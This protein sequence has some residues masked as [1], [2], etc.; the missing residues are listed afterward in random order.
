MR[1]ALLIEWWKVRRSPVTLT[2]TALM[3]LVLPAMGLGFYNVALSDAN[4]ILAD[5]AT[6][7][8]VGDGWDG[9]LGLVD[10]IAAVA[11]LL[12]VGVVVAWVF[13]REHVDRTFPSLFAH[14]TSRR[15]MAMAKF[16]VMFG[17]VVVVSLVIAALSFLLGVV[18]GVGPLE[19][20]GLL[21]GLLR[22]VAIA[23]C[24]GVLGLTLALVSSAGRGYLPAI[25]ALIL[26][27]AAAQVAVLFGTGGWFPYA[28]PGL[29]AVAGAEGA[30][31]ILPIQIAMVPGLTAVAL[32][33]TVRW[34]RTAEVA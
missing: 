30:P 11:V 6:A 22:L 34:W 32:W 9:Y 10:Q 14:A 5:K 3:G 27:I 1:A 17:W 28:I 25:G 16:V 7:F 19:E 26:I 13:G 21:P 20:P 24:A 18:S 4:G 29:L 12:G 23:I 15:S 2:A 33:L 8:L 31:T